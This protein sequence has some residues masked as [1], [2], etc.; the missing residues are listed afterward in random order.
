MF[1]SVNIEEMSINPFLDIPKGWFLITSGNKENFNTMT[2]SWGTLGHIWRRNVVTMMVRPQRHTFDFIENNDCFSISFFDET[3]KDMLTYCGRHSGKD[4][5]KIKET[6][7]TPLFTEGEIPY[8]KEAHTVLICQ[9]L[10]GQ[11]L[12]K[13]LFIE[14]SI[15]DMSYTKNDFH[16]LYV[17]EILQV[18]TKK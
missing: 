5:D 8:F 17:S 10:Y 18:L 12:E 3:Y 16:K 15:L 4:Y 9:K 7:I 6:N 2:A 14:K 13:D 1:K 11:F